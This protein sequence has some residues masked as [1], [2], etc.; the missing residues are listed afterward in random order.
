[1][2][3]GQ[4][5]NGTRLNTSSTINFR[6]QPWGNFGITY[7]YNKVDL[8]GEFGE[9]DLHLFRTNVQISFSNSMFLTSSLQFNSQSENYNFFT[10]FQWR[11][12]PMS[13]IFLVY[14]DNY[15]MN[16]LGIKNRQVVFKA[17]YWLNL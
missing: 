8:P 14:T 15:E 13:D 6:T 7:N 2:E 4:F 5:F 3:Y 17:T 16:G 12:R 11:Y 1:M 10:R 9:A